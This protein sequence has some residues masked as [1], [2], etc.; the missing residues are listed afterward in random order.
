AKKGVACTRSEDNLECISSIKDQGMNDT[1]DNLGEFIS[2]KNEATKEKNNILKMIERVQEERLT[3]Y[4]SVKLSQIGLH[5]DEEFCY[6][7]IKEILTD[8]K[9][10]N[11]FV[12][13]DM[14]NF[15]SKAPTLV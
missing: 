11:M 7:N 14:K 13:L 15:V 6:N 2:D 4:P 12:N 1:F 8:D 10:T 5:I 9:K 3:A